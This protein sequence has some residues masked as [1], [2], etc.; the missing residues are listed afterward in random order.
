MRR[1]RKTEDQTTFE[2]PL[3]L[4]WEIVSSSHTNLEF[5]G[6]LPFWY[7]AAITIIELLLLYPVNQS[8]KSSFN[9]YSIGSVS[10]IYS[11]TFV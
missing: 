3:G 11:L 1:G 6:S 9:I 10:L 4:W 5:P 8:N 2:N 7:E